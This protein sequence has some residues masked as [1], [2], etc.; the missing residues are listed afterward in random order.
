M[1]L[2]TPNLDGGQAGDFN[3]GSTHSCDPKIRVAE[4]REVVGGGEA[5]CSATASYLRGAI[6]GQ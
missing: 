4:G 6:T 1:F 3:H 2:T 5:T